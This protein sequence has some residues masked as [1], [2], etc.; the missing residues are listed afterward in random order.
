MSK[1]CT[2]NRFLESA[3]FNSFIQ[4]VSI[5]PLQ[6]HYYS[7]ALPTQHEYCVEV[8]RRKPQATAS[9]GLAQG[10]YVAARAGFKPATIRTKGVKSTNGPP[11]PIIM[12]ACIYSCIARTY[13]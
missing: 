11:R 13:T 10:P 7:E 9:E 3:Y 1:M 2:A 5:A 4:V 6:V 8:S 12:C